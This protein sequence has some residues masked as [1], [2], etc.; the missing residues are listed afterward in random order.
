[1]E[2]VPLSITIEG[3]WWFDPD[4]DIDNVADLTTDIINLN[5]CAG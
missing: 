5:I 1:M 2:I 4:L 3:Y